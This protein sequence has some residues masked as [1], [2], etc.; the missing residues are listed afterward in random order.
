M[1]SRQPSGGARPSRLRCDDC[2][3]APSCKSLFFVR[4]AVVQAVSQVIISFQRGYIFY[5]MPKTGSTTLHYLLGLRSDSDIV[6]AGFDHGKHVDCKTTLR[7]L[8]HVF[9]V[10]PYP[11]FIKFGVI[12]EPLELLLSWYRIWSDEKLADPANPSHHLWLQGRSL[13]DLVAELESG[14]PGGRHFQ[15]AR[16]FYFLESGELGVDYL[17]R[18]EYMADDIAPLERLLPLGLTNSV[19]ATRL[20]A[21]R[22]SG[23][24]SA[25]RGEV[26]DALRARIYD[27]F[28]GDLAL[29]NDVERINAE[30]LQS[31][32][33]PQACTQGLAIFRRCYPELYRH[34]RNDKMRA[35]AKHGLQRL[36]LRSR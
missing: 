21:T 34:S 14:P 8:P 11:C 18:N 1:A 13:E 5:G 27:L 12:R 3:C 22:R 29:Y 35:R 4:S 23:C 6:L 2:A 28:A 10:C 7:D 26:G 25:G 36:G 20:N 15:T 17:V 24:A 19:R 9:A 16:S 30:F 33:Q 31:Q 32:V